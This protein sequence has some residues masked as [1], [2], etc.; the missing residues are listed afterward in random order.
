MLEFYGLQLKGV[1]QR[2]DLLK[3][4]EYIQLQKTTEKINAN[5]VEMQ[6]ACGKFSV[7]LDQDNKPVCVPTPKQKK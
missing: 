5:I 3:T 7:S 6:K 4:N 1:K 2:E